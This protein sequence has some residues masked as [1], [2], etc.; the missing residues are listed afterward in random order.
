MRQ[1][2]N[3]YDGFSPQRYAVHHI[4]LSTIGHAL[5][6]SRVAPQVVSLL[7]PKLLACAL[8]VRSQLHLSLT[9]VSSMLITS[10][11][12]AL[13]PSKVVVGL[14][15]SDEHA[16]LKHKHPPFSP[17][18]SPFLQPFPPPPP[19]ATL[20]PPLDIPPFPSFTNILL[21]LGVSHM[22]KRASAKE[23]ELDSTIDIRELAFRRYGFTYL[24]HGYQY[25]RR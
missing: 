16:D 15:F 5:S 23:G 1:R 13:L 25:A 3:I 20:T 9:T 10:F 19:I 2:T 7:P 4:D 24:R 11:T 12:L 8:T 21:P 22:L 6:N 18:V 17:S 14:H